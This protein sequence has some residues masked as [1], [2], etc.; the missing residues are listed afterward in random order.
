MENR[1]TDVAVAFALY[2]MMKRFEPTNIYVRILFVD[3]SSAFSAVILEKLFD[4]LQLKSLDASICL[5][6]ID[7]SKKTPKGCLN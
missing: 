7:F 6:I 5:C 3:Y 1:C 4:K 2:F